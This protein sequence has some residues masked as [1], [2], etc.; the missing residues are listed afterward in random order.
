MKWLL[1]FVPIAFGLN[2][3]HINPIIVFFASALAIIPLAS[4]MEQAT[5]VL[6]KY[7]GPTFGG[8]LSAT[9]GNAPEL[10]IGISALNN[11]LIEVLKGSIAGSIIGTLLFGLGVTM[12]SGGLRK[13]VQTFDTAMVS[14]NNGLL[15][16]TAFGLIIPAVFKFSSPVDQEISTHISIL[17]LIIYTASLVYTLRNSHTPIG[18][19]GVE[20]ALED[21]SEEQPESTHE[22]PKWSRNMATMILGGVTIVLAFVSDLLTDT[23]Q[24]ASDVMGLTPS[25]AGVFLLA[26]VGNVP[27]YLNAM[28]FAYKRQ[29]TLALSVNL[30]STSQLALLVAPILVLSGQY[31]GL[32]MNLTFSPFELIGI[33]LAVMISRHLLTDNRTTWL[34]GVMLI[35]VY[36]M[37][38]VGFYYAPSA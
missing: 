33:I 3:F 27:Q 26:L 37:L 18:K 25:F 24:P 31:M 5:E 17:M 15:S 32:N 36:S 28:S 10:I 30:S 2:S 20:H 8:L 4:L 16:V 1:L 34:E 9:M 23:I 29:L 21:V 19:E 6:S 11:G 35:V 38:G 7:L 14:M 22:A 13:P 12:I